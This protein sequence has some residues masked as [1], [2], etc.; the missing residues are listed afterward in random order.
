MQ[1][2]NLEQLKIPLDDYEKVIYQ[3][4]IYAEKQIPDFIKLG[5]QSEFDRDAFLFVYLAGHGCADYRQYFLLDEK[6]PDLIFW[7]AEAEN[8]RLLTICGKRCK[9]FIVYDCW[10]V[11]GV[12]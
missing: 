9:S 12:L 1:E 6:D 11:F 3:R 7:N 2:K 5:K 8:R 4:Y 10:C